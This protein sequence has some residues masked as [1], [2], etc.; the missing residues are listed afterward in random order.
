MITRAEAIRI[1][2]EVDPQATVI[3]VFAKGY[4]FMRKEDRD[5]ISDPGFAVSKED[6]RVYMGF[7]ARIFLEDNLFEENPVGKEEEE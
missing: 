1:A 7:S 2:K 3:S 5:L 6:G 4:H